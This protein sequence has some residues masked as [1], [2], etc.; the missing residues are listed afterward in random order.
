M[1]GNG[2][3]LHTLRVQCG[4]YGKAGKLEDISTAKSI[5]FF[6]FK[7]ILR[8]GFF[9]THNDLFL[10]KIST[11]KSRVAEPPDFGN[12]SFFWWVSLA[13]GGS[14][15]DL[16]NELKQKILSHGFASYLIESLKETR[17]LASC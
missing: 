15:S 12:Y 3:T 7:F 14:G 1:E 13:G 2:C 17:M 11:L 16:I 8:P 5:S 9:F 6:K 4:Q 10:N